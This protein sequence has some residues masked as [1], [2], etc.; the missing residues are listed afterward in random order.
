MPGLSKFYMVHRPGNRTLPNL[1]TSAFQSKKGPFPAEPI[2]KLSLP[3]LIHW[4]HLHL[5]GDLFVW[6]VR[7]TF[8]V[9]WPDSWATT[10]ILF[11]LVNQRQLRWLLAAFLHQACPT[12]VEFSTLVQVLLLNPLDLITCGP[13]AHLMLTL[14]WKKQERSQPK[15]IVHFKNSSWP[16]SETFGTH[17][18]CF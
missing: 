11:F 3:T 15:I 2:S 12:C 16:Q 1:F 13:G 5:E 18:A 4:L 14:P 10:L 7:W 17:L 6:L 8:E 9:R